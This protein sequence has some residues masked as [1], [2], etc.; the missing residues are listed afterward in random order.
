MKLT[1]RNVRALE[2][3]EV[4]LGD[5]VLVCGENRSGKSSVCKA[6]AACLMGDPGIIMGG[7]S[8]EARAR[9][10]V[11]E[12]EDSASATL[13]QDG[14]GTVTV[15]WP[16]E[17]VRTK[18]RPPH[19]SPIATGTITFTDM[20]PKERARF[21]VEL[22]GLEPTKEDL[23]RGLAE[24]G[25][26]NLAAGEFDKL[27]DYAQTKGWDDAA[28]S[29]AESATKGK[30][31]WERVTRKKWGEKQAA[32][33]KPEGYENDD[34]LRSSLKDLEARVA[35]AQI[36]IDAA[37]RARTLTEADRQRMEAQVARIPAIQ[38]ALRSTRAHLSELTA[39]IALCEAV[40]APVTCSCPECGVDVVWL[41]G[42]K[43]TKVSE[44]STYD[45][46]EEQRKRKRRAELVP[47]H[48][49]KAD[50]ERHLCADLDHAH[51][52][53]VHLKELGDLPASGEAA[54]EDAERALAEAK[55]HVKACKEAKEAADTH[56]D[57]MRK[58]AIAKVLGP[59]GIRA[60]KAGAGLTELNR[61]LFELTD[62]TS[63]PPVTITPDFEVVGERGRPYAAM[64]PSEQFRAD[65]V[66]QLEIAR[67]DCS[68]MAIIDGADIVVGLQA[69]NDL[70]EVIYRAEI[71]AV[72]GLAV[73]EAANAPDLGAAGLGRTYFTENGTARLLSQTAKAEAA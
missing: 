71:A 73:S 52:A 70:I 56:A 41:P 47:L 20:A 39:E 3:A 5:L 36:D 29:Y 68:D 69:R 23:E 42:G 18:G 28:K 34:L 72:I 65:T 45:A 46:Q 12:G 16:G 38:E 63:W 35:K 66:L 1:I 61:A 43:L 14:A 67:R 21:I 57:I 4:E 40:S 33:W 62:E 26:A 53:E 25:V 59:E 15:S 2:S 58:L 19:A 55:A 9:G 54:V 51:R 11:R 8:K 32:T 7:R 49:K 37:K 50:E 27:W 17:E 30:G 13:V 10:V 31:A 24:A 22:L 6:L 64:T 48:G 44:D 60:V